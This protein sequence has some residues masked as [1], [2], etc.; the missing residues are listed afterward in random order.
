[1][2]RHLQS[3]DP[4]IAFHLYPMALVEL[5]MADGVPLADLLVDTGLDDGVI[6]DDKASISYAQYGLLIRNAFRRF[7]RPGL[8]LHFGQA[9]HVGHQGMLGVAAMTADTLR[10]AAFLTQRF[11]KFLSPALVIEIREE[12]DDCVVQ[13]NEAWD[14]GP[15]RPFAVECLFVGLYRNMCFVMGLEE[16]ACRF[17]FGYDPPAYAAQYPQYLPGEISFRS[18]FNQIRF[19]VNLLDAPLRFRHPLTCGQATQLIEDWAATLSSR[20]SVLMKLR[21][22]PVV[23]PGRVLSLEEAAARLFMSERTLKRQL[24]KLNTHY[25]RVVDTMRF[26]W[27][28]S[29]LRS[30]ELSVSDIAEQ[31]CFSDVANFRRAFKRWAGQTPQDY[32]AGNG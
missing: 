24:Q 10:D 29:A 28:A 25:R 27:A 4:V 12:G 2:G 1:M 26:E 18:G 7:S 31:M 9:L 22:I 32:R 30:T 21:Q 8:G 14:L 3:S 5:L 23:S 20:D 15:L 11:Y 17:D 19:D 13:A 16:F 6:E